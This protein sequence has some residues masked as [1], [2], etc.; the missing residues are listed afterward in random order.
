MTWNQL[1]TYFAHG[2]L[3]AGVAA[4]PLTAATSGIIGVASC[5]SKPSHPYSTVMNKRRNTGEGND[6]MKERRV[7][8]VFGTS[9]RPWPTKGKSYG[10][11]QQICGLAKKVVIM[12]RLTLRF[13]VWLKE[14]I[15]FS[16]TMAWQRRWLSSSD[17]LCIF[18]V[19]LHEDVFFQQIWWATRT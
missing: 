8:E 11:F 2:S 3:F 4:P 5:A 14:E 17:L 16:R 15:A 1:N 13:F 18:F 10:F 7:P 9:H 6:G 12:S 19:W